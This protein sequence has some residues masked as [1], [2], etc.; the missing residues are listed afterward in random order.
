VLM[1]D[2]ERTFHC[3]LFQKMLLCCK[4]DS[5]SKDAKKASKTMS[6]SKKGKMRGRDSS[7]PAKSP[8]HV[9]GRLYIRD[10]REIRIPQDRSNG[11]AEQPQ[12]NL[13]LGKYYITIHYRPEENHDQP[14]IMHPRNE[15]TM[16]K[17]YNTLLD[18][19]RRCLEVEGSLEKYTGGLLMDPPGLQRKNTSASDRT[20]TTNSRS[21]FTSKFDGRIDITSPVTP[22]GS[23][24]DDGQDDNL[25]SLPMSRNGSTTSLNGHSNHQIPRK[26]APNRFPPHAHGLPPHART[27]SLSTNEYGG[28]YFSPMV[29]TPPVPSNRPISP[30]GTQQFP[31]PLQRN[32]EDSRTRSR[33]GY[34]NG[35]PTPPLTARS[36]ID[37]VSRP[38]VPPLAASRSRS[39][40]TPNIHQIQT[41]LNRGKELP[42]PL[43]VAVGQRDRDS[44]SPITPHSPSSPITSSRPTTGTSTF[45]TTFSSIPETPSSIS[46]SSTS[47][48]RKAVPSTAGSTTSLDKTSAVKVKITYGNDIFVVV[49]PSDVTY[50]TL[51]AKVRHKLHVCSNVSKD[52][53]LRLKYQDEDGDYVTIR[54]DEDVVLAIE[55][56]TQPVNVAGATIAGAG[57]INL[58]VSSSAI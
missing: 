17:W 35:I 58:L 16:M 34:T 4:D 2:K 25:A 27:G 50:A 12:F 36:L 29:D 11:T 49:V 40:S 47:A 13:S 43:P 8:L 57:I 22:P 6:M 52:G 45:N 5:L 33:D 30:N 56:R 23:G 18:L 28:S 7:V 39:A 10:I 9:K 38:S 24:S 54:S 32:E 53:T 55:T 48:T 46:S 21:V 26:P 14:L 44:G 51:L 19:H 37:R 20:L 41:N 42:P 15:E 1:G 31:F 3:F